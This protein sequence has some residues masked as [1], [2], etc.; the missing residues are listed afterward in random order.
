MA[1]EQTC[2]LHKHQ[3]HCHYKAGE[4]RDMIPTEALALKH[5]VGNNGKDNEADDFLDHLELH[6]TEGSS[7]LVK[8]NAVGRYLKTILKK[9]DT[10]AEDYHSQ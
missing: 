1:A 9:G 3:I 10:P 8:A 6:Q 2:L 4:G 7:I 5:H